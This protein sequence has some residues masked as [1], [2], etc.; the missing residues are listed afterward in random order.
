[1]YKHPI[2]LF[3]SLLAV[4]LS[5][6]KTQD[7]VTICYKPG[8]DRVGYSMNIPYTKQVSYIY[9]DAEFCYFFRYGQ[10]TRSTCLFIEY[11]DNSFRGWWQFLINQMLEKYG[12]QA[13]EMVN[14]D[15]A[16]YVASYLVADSMG[17]SF[18][19]YQSL[20]KHHIFNEKGQWEGNTKFR[21][22]D[23]LSAV[24]TDTIVYEGISDGLAWKWF[25][26]SYGI[27]VGYVNVPLDEKSHFD[28][29]ILSLHALQPDLIG[30]DNFWK[31]YL[32][33]VKR[34]S[35]LPEMKLEQI[36]LENQ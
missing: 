27:T 30:G 34:K 36:L 21:L 9:G 18:P 23:T 4:I 26:V 8:G 33:T 20:R 19:V 3:A 31:T 32:A 17:V 12:E 35:E 14:T 13:Y 15:T 22:L 11:A 2:L 16:Q 29:C 6:C 1:M 28:D 7:Y 25:H 5:S 24:K 10:G